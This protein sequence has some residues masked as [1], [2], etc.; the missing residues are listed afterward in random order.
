MASVKLKLLYLIELL[1]SH[2]DEAHRLTVPELCEL[3]FCEYNISAERKSVYRDLDLLTEYG[4]DVVK[5]SG[6]YYLGRREF[7]P[8]QLSLLA[9]AVQ[10]AA[11]ISP[12]RS[13]ELLDRLAWPLSR[14]Q[15]KELLCSANLYGVKCAGDDVYL[16]IEAVNL[17]I[18]ARRQITFTYVKRD[19][20]KRSVLQ[21]SGER[22]RVSPY[23]M[24]WVQD[25]YY[26]VGNMEG[27]D[28]LTHFRLDRMQSVRIDVQS[29]R[30]FREVSQYQD[31]FNGAEYAARALNMFGGEPAHIRLRCK[32]QMTSALIDRFG[33][34]VPLRREQDPNYF[35]ADL[36]AA[37]NEGFI[38]WAAQFGGLL[39]ILEPPELRDRMKAHLEEALESYRKP[40]D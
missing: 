37:P 9:A 25:R 22:Y 3:L 38:G 4:Y 10:A 12:R 5:T 13:R 16:A 33:L 23:A 34:D 11:F 17:A 15:A 26:M 30:H 7:E 36:R 32:M 6:G 39:E 24:I 18:A 14:Y 2:T 35:T 8:W 20:N 21:R 27:R 40:S 19:I 31:V 28:D 29:A 1:R